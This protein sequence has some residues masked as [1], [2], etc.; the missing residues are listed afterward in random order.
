[1]AYFVPS[2]V[3]NGLK[4][5]DKEP[6]G[7]FDSSMSPSSYD[8]TVWISS[9]SK[10]IASVFI[11]VSL[12]VKVVTLPKPIDLTLPVGNLIFAFTTKKGWV[13]LSL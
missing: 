11:N 1:M 12:S 10:K 9:L 6:L 5:N 4:S 8:I 2:I 13:K 3:F 7:N